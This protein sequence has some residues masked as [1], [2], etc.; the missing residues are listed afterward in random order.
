M[1]EIEPDGGSISVLLE[2]HSDLG[3]FEGL[4][5][6]GGNFV[7]FGDLTAE[8]GR[9]IVSLGEVAFQEGGAVV[10]V[11]VKAAVGTGVVGADVHAGRAAAGG[12]L[13][14]VFAGLQGDAADA[15]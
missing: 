14:G 4:G 11:T 12:T 2:I 10:G 13:V 1:G 5:F 9:R 7:A 15:A 6:S 8:D 3:V